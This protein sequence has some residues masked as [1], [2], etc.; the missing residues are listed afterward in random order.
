M[1]AVEE[2]FVRRKKIHISGKMRV[3]YS[4]VAVRYK[5]SALHVSLLYRY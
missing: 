5:Q 3:Q 1:C 2:T 4:E